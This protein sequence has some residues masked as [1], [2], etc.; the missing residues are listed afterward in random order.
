[1]VALDGGM[2][3]WQRR[4]AEVASFR[5]MRGATGAHPFDD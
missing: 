4:P 5:G 3:E 1:M 2:I